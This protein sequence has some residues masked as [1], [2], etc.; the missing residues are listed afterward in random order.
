MS[1]RVLSATDTTFVIVHGH[2]SAVCSP[3][4]PFHD[5]PQG[6]CWQLHKRFP[7]VDEAKSL[8]ASFSKAAASAL[9]RKK[10]FV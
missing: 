4:L 6:T 5:P 1:A 2:H 3:L 7:D 10:N 9:H 8:T